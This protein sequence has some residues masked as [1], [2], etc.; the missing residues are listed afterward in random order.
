M[1]SL[2]MFSGSFHFLLF[3]GRECMCLVECTF[4]VFFLQCSILVDFIIRLCHNY[5]NAAFWLHLLPCS[6]F[7]S[8]ECK[9][10]LIFYHLCPAEDMKCL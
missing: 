2:A 5:C 7:C 4:P 1:K 6:E 8:S 9:M 10:L 3:I